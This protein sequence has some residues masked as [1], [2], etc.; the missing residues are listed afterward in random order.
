M[1]MSKFYSTCYEYG[2]SRSS[3]T[4]C[5]HRNI[6]AAAQSWDG[7]VIT[8]LSYNDAGDLIIQI[9]VADDSRS[10]SGDH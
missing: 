1:L 3:A 10:G 7:S 4:R 6:Y 8:G 9:Q 2:S 5:G